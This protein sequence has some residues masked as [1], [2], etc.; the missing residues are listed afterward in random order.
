MTLD[1]IYKIVVFRPVTP[2]RWGVDE[3]NSWCPSFLL[4]S[5]S[6][7]QPRRRSLHRT[8]RSPWAEETKIE[9]AG[10]CSGMSQG[11]RTRAEGPLQSP[12][13][14]W[15]R[16]TCIEITGKNLREKGKSRSLRVQPRITVSPEQKEPWTHREGQNPQ[17]SAAAGMGAPPKLKDCWGHII[18]KRSN[19]SQGT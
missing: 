9:V 8:Q 15:A 14:C 6:G 13:N 1:K 2:E 18:S 10:T 4:E 11:T 19:R 3:M 17:R 5:V 12:R 7:R 16:D